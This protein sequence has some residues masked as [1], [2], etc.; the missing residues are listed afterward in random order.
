M[1]ILY[2]NGI[3][4]FQKYLIPV[5]CAV[6]VHKDRKKINRTSR[7]KSGSFKA[8]FKEQKIKQKKI[9]PC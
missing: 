3:F 9:I 2:C 7:G 6:C 5:Q 1:C 8:N 4:I